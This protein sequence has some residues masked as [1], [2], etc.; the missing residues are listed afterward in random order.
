VNSLV[1]REML[2]KDALVECEADTLFIEYFGNVKTG[3]KGI[4]VFR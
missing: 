2:G 4:R 3:Q 1:S